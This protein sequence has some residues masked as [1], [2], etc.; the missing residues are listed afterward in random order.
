MSYSFN[1]DSTVLSSIGCK[2]YN[3]F[4]YG[5]DALSSWC[6][7]YISIEKFISVAYP[8]KRF[9]FKK[10]KNQIIFCILLGLF[11]ILYHLN[12]PF[13]FDVIL[14][15]DNSSSCEFINNSR[16]LINNMDLV[17]C[18][19]APFLFMIIFSILLIIVIF[20]TRSRVRLNNSAREIERLKRDVKFSISLLLINLLF[21]LLNLPFLIFIIIGYHDDYDLF[22]ILSYICFISYAINFYIILFTNSLF[23]LEFYSL[24]ITNQQQQQTGQIIEMQTQKNR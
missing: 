3:F 1:F 11:N 10:N 22:V 23:R 24:F 6:L 21:I 2:I 15:D 16:L 7:V 20:K 8:H 19:L 17:N 4:S 14:N 5:L 18:V 13:S 12:V 9:V